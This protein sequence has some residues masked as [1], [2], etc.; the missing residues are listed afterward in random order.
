MKKI[1]LLAPILILFLNCTKNHGY[2]YDLETK[3]PMKGVIVQDVNNSN[4]KVLTDVDGKFSF[5]NCGNLIIIKV[6]Y[7]VDTLEKFGCKPNG[8]CFDGHIFYMI[9]KNRP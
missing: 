6:G 2:I 1:L 5:S 8:K 9:K 3:N 7:Y 4:N